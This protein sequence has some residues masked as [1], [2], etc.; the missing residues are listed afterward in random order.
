MKHWFG[1]ALILFCIFVIAVSL[2]GC[3]S[4]HYDPTPE[5]RA[6][7]YQRLE[8][9]RQQRQFEQSIERAIERAKRRS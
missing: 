2:V 7:E 9:M 5:E 3:S 4:Y 8:I 1:G 6:E